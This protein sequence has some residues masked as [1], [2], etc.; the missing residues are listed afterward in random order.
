MNHY[1]T[2]N[3]IRELRRK[4]NDTQKELGE[5]IGISDKTISKWET[6]RGLP[7]MTLLEPLAAALGVSIAELLSGD[8]ITNANRSGNVLRSKWYVCP[9][10]GNVIWATGE[11]VFSCCGIQ[12][13]PLE[14]EDADLEHV[15]Q[16]ER[17]EDDWYVTL[18][19]PMEKEHYISFIAYVS[20]D[21]MQLV[22][23]YPEQHAEAGFFIRGAG[24]FYAYCNRH[25]LFALAAGSIRKEAGS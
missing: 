4:M 14:V 11:G 3:S 9:V 2:G 24:R 10:C 16:A 21:R 8:C 1:V 15:L 5:K 19:H 6:G 18:A 17:I 13:P 12:L 7:D 22:K 23:L 25:G 20:G